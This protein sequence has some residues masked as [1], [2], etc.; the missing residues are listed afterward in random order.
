MNLIDARFQSLRTAGRKAFLP[1]LT[2]G[3]PSL[4]ATGELI[5]GVVDAG[6]DIVE[7]GFPYSD[8]IADGPVIQ[9]SYTRALAR[10]I[11]VDAIFA[12][13][14]DWCRAVAPVPLVAMISYSL[15][16]R[17]GTERFLDQATAAGFSGAIIPDLPVDEAEAVSSSASPAESA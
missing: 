1:F 6:A 15:V 12:L 11:R 13:A 3:D 7:V 10:G 2:A 17:R 8:P 9:A 14:A 4:E 16:H 5:R